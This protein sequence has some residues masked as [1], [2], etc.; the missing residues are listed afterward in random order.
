MSAICLNGVVFNSLYAIVS[1]PQFKDFLQSK[2]TNCG[3]KK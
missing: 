1:G 2:K 3:V